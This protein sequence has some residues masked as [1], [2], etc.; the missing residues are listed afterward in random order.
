[1]KKYL[2]ILIAVVSMSLFTGCEADQEYIP[3]N[4]V[5]FESG[6]LNAGV[7]V[8]GTATYD[9]VV[10]TANITGSDRQFAVNVDASS[11]LSSEGYT[12]PSSVTIPGGSNEGVISVQVSDVNLG[13]T[14][15]TLQLSLQSEPDLSVGKPFK[16][17]VARTCVGK[18]FVVDFVFD[19]Y[20]SETSW[21]LTDDTGAVLV[22]QGGYS[23][24]TP[25][26]SKSLCLSPGTYTFTVKDSYGD[27]LTYPNLGSVTLSYAG[28]ELA[29][30]PGDFGAETSVEVTF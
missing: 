3:L 19:G 14:G 20:A 28:N 8:G 26:A 9:V 16:I 5:T 23:D 2:I 17:N 6:S 11:T 24:D 10:Y 22:E 12:I 29:V 7:D 21:S 30:I 18:E 27:G 4:Y 25:T 15:K 1:M 13:V